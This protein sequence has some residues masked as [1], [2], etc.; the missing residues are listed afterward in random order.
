MGFLFFFYLFV[1]IIFKVEIFINMN[2]IKVFEISI[3][4]FL[5]ILKL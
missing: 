3:Y 5:E 1:G 2:E 4:I